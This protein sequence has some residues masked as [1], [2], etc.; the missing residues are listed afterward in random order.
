MNTA[1]L[2]LIVNHIPVVGMIFALVFYV[3]A[4]VAGK[5]LLVKAAIWIFFFVALSAIPAYLTGEPAHE[6]I[7]DFPGVSHDIVHEH[8]ETAEVAFITSML[9]GLLA[10][11]G[12]VRLRRKRR[13]SKLFLTLMLLVAVVVGALLASAANQGGEIRHPE[14]R[15]TG[16]L[17]PR[18]EPGFSAP[19]T[20]GAD[21]QPDSGESGGVP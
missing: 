4:L 11:L 10:L 7:K 15:S 16:A 14:I 17:S 3:A 12:L 5:D 8:E 9:L 19:D 1:H 18:I 6:V 13:L 21:L 2:H 20:A